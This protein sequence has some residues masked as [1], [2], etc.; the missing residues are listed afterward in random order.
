M[1]FGLELPAPRNLL[2]ADFS[3]KS[4]VPTAT[5]FRY[6][7]RAV[8]RPS[9]KGNLQKITYALD[10]VVTPACCFA[11]PP[12]QHPRLSTHEGQE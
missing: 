9:W 7:G 6:E 11:V 2:I 12:R 3:E 10:Q 1:I 5:V 4:G 8:I